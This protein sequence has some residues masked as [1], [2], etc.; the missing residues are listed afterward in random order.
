MKEKLYLLDNTN[1]LFDI[2][3][4]RNSFKTVATHQDC[5]LTPITIDSDGINLHYFLNE[6]KVSQNYRKIVIRNVKLKNGLII[7]IKPPKR[8]I[9]DYEWNY[10][11]LQLVFFAAEF[12]NIF[13]WM[14]T[15]GGAFSSLG[16]QFSHFVS[17]FSIFYL[18]FDLNRKSCSIGGQS[19]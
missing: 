3:L 7:Q 9:L 16:D 18:S 11:I 8:E 6:L 10:K 5:S 13:S 2:Q 1:K 17:I 15:L 14:S 12:D 19:W 4:N